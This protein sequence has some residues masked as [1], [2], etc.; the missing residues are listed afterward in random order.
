MVSGAALVKSLS[1]CPHGADLTQ[2]E[3][4]DSQRASEALRAPV[5]ENS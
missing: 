5:V 2:A 3:A 4:S 1:V